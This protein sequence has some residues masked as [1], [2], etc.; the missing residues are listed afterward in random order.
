MQIY[1]HHQRISE[2][3]IVAI[4]VVLNFIVNVSQVDSTVSLADVTVIHAKITYS[5]KVLDKKLLHRHL[6]AHQALSVLRLVLNNSQVLVG[7]Q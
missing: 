1:K 5:T 3:V 7:K 2:D 4:V 6:N